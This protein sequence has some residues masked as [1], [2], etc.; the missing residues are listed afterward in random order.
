MMAEVLEECMHARY[1]T[2]TPAQKEVY[3]LAV[4]DTETVNTRTTDSRTEYYFVNALGL[5]F[6][7]RAIR[8]RFSETY[9][10]HNTMKHK[11]DGF[12]QS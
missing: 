2:P 8:G 1:I 12:L 4:W 10:Y 3:R 11:E 5:C 9:F 7:D 6:E